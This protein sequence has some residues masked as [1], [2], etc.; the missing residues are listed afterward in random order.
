MPF[1]PLTPTRLALGRPAPP[2]GPRTALTRMVRQLLAA[3]LL[4]GAG[5]ALAGPVPWPQ[6]P[7]SHFADNQKLESVLGDFAGSF[8]LSLSL[9]PGIGGVVNGKFTTASPTEFMS[10]LAGVYGFVW[11]THAGTLF[12]SKASDLTTRSISPPGGSIANV[13]KALTDLGVLDPRFGWG[14][15][16]AQGVALVSGPPSYVDLIESTVKG[17]PNAGGAQQ[18]AVFRLRNAS[19]DDRTI[20][21][22][23]RQITLPGLATILRNLVTGQGRG[24][25]NNE[26]LS[27]IAAP[28][29]SAASMSTEGLG[30]NT[31]SGPGNGVNARNGSGSQGGGANGN[32][33]GGQGGSANPG[34]GDVAGASANRVRLPT[35]QSDPRLNALIIQD[36]PE[37]MPIYRQLIEQL[38]VPTALIEIEAMIIDVNTERAKDLGIN[39][40]GRAGSTALG[41]GTPSS[42]PAAGTLSV[43]RGVAGS[44][45]TPSSLVVDAGNYLVSQIR[46]LETKGDARIQS[47]PSVMTMDNIG[48]LLDLSE[49]FYIRVQGERVATVTPVTAGTTLKVTPRT[50]IENGVRMVQLMIDIE[51]G[52]IQDRQIDTLP[53]VRRSSV[54]TQAVVRSDDTL[55]IAGHTQD[56]NIDSLQKIPL[57]GDIPGFGTL[58]S[59]R[60][61]NVQRRE[62]LFMIKPRIITLPPGQDMGETVIRPLPSPEATPPVSATTVPATAVAA[63]VVTPVVPAVVN[64]A[65][66]AKPGFMLHMGGL[67]ADLAKVVRARAARILD[68]P[69]EELTLQADGALMRVQ[70]GPFAQLDDAMAAARKIESSMNLQPRLVAVQTPG[71]AN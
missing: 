71:T 18:A 41:F 12:V 38:D 37:R 16:T 45:V 3:S 57:L 42:T 54:S 17:L 68:L 9:S 5:L 2:G 61:A 6:A 32:A 70:A 66:P 59:N 55:L 33:G 25:I 35:V 21:Y 11:Y 4:A 36:V 58:F 20:L 22:R 47:R 31:Q 23:D 50:L 53:T 14:E 1:L 51:D 26:A 63:V 48:A 67:A 24:G 65:P 46:I 69:P 64:A 8:S 52:Q 27:A 15:L 60:S 7:Y 28:L 29:L 44:L 10:K 49:T 13:R 19:A 43:V 39:W 62:R 30:S 34:A 56:Q 40:G